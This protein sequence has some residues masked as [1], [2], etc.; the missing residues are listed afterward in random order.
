MIGSHG[1]EP[2]FSSLPYPPICTSVFWSLREHLQGCRHSPQLPFSMNHRADDGAIGGRSVCV[3]CALGARM[4]RSRASGVVGGLALSSALPTGDERWLQTRI[5]SAP[6]A[7]PPPNW[8]THISTSPA[9]RWWRG[10][11]ARLAASYAVASADR[12]N[13]YS[14]AHQEA[15]RETSSARPAAEF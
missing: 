6:N 11:V 1:L 14:V 3:G 13:L 2:H 7:R 4:T 9:C 15:G 10:V 5:S 8:K 12:L